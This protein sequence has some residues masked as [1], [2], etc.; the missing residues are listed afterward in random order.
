MGQRMAVPLRDDEWFALYFSRGHMVGVRL[1][2]KLEASIAFHCEEAGYT[3][4]CCF[5]GLAVQKPDGA[6]FSLPG[7]G[8]EGMS[9]A[10]RARGLMRCIVMEAYAA[11]YEAVTSTD[12]NR[13]SGTSAWI[14]RKA[15]PHSTLK[16]LAPLSIGISSTDSLQIAGPQDAV[17]IAERAVEA[18]YRGGV[19]SRS[20]QQDVQVMKLKGSPWFSSSTEQLMNGRVLL[21]GLFS[22]L[23]RQ[24]YGLAT[25]C[26]HKGTSDT[27]FFSNCQPSH[28]RFA[29]LSL[30]ST[31][32]LRLLGLDVEEIGIV[33]ST[34]KSYWVAIQQE[35]STA[36]YHEFKLKGTPWWSNGTDAVASRGL[37][38]HLLQ[39]LR[40]VGW[41][42]H[43]ALDVSRKDSDKSSI[44]LRRCQPA[45]LQHMCI[46]FNETD[47][48]RV[49]NCP[50][51]VDAVRATLLQWPRGISKEREYG[52]AYEFKLNGNPWGHHFERSAAASLAMD[53]LNTMEQHGWVLACA[54]DTSAKYYRDDS[55]DYPIDVDSWYFVQCSETP[56]ASAP[57]LPL[58][59]AAGS[60]SGMSVV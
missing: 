59:L 31:D 8:H 54:C 47:K 12:L 11:G 4:Q 36:L 10:I 13:Y 27:L 51:M 26:N 5:S 34:V 44:M 60:A 32:K 30:N 35:N 48:V 28:D 45:Q 24:G 50:N 29:M 43:C 1:P 20:T 49:L 22:D 38:M 42:A 41:E 53:L 7:L 40:A 15:K 17:R 25:T 14:F 9:S 39:A 52:G 37:V 2:L 33:R 23:A 3:E 19:Q 58:Q 56:E 6:W 46:S 57:P 16:C 21:L 55:N 18:H